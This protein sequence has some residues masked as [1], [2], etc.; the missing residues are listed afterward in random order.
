MDKTIKIDARWLK[1]ALAVAGA[2]LLLA[3]FYQQA[4]LV[5][6]MLLTSF[7]LAFVLAPLC[8]LFM[9]VGI[10]SRALSVALTFL[11]AILLLAALLL[12]LVPPILEQVRE[13]STLMDRSSSAIQTLLDQLNAFLRARELPELDITKIDWSFLTGGI[14][15]MLNSSRELAGGVIGWIS[16]FGLSLMMAFYFLLYKQ[17][18]LLNLE[19]LIP[20]GARK[21]VL[22]MTASVTRELRQYLKGQLTI[23]LIVGVLAGV[24]L[25][26]VRVPS[27]LLLG[28][29][30]GVFNLIPYFGPLIGG[31]PAVLMALGQ[32]LPMALMTALVLFIVQQLDGFVIAP[33][34]MSGMTGLS[35]PAVLL[36]ITVGSSISGISGMF[37]AIPVLLIVRICLRVW[38]SRNEVIEKYPEM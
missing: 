27:A 1:I 21:I 36:A 34:V 29:I 3:L 22:M 33:R 2:V 37:F 30:V 11:L 38:A 4:M 10:K 28:A 9:R 24:G 31:I 17:N 12:L 20:S 26:I 18:M 25:M 16:R 8:E 7:I 23:A 15:G 19:L 6:S 13:L 35:P 32:G 14:A 5:L